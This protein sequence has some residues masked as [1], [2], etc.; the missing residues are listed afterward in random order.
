MKDRGS[1][2]ESI[3]RECGLSAAHLEPRWYAVYTRSR[4]EKSVAE[5]LT[6]PRPPRTIAARNHNSFGTVYGVEPY[7]GSNN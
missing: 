6:R 1:L 3:H 5:Q 4:H 7:S 2:R